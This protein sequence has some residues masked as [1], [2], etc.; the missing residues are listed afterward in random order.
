M[1][2]PKLAA[3]AAFALLAACEPVPPPCKSPRTAEIARLDALIAETRATIDRGYVT[4][5]AAP[6]DVTVCLGG[7]SQNVGISF[8]TPSG[9]FTRVAIDPAAEKRKLASLNDKRAAV[10]RQAEAE[11]AQC[12]ARQGAAG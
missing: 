4:V 10:A 5:P 1:H 9:G 6:A 3:L 2:F 7:A 12:R 8:C 11:I